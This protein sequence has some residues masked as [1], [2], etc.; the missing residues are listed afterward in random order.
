MDKKS[1]EL[2][3]KHFLN[4]ELLKDMLVE[5][6]DQTKFSLIKEEIKNA[7]LE[8]LLGNTI[9]PEMIKYNKGTIIKVSP[10]PIFSNSYYVIFPNGVMGNLRDNNFKI[11]RRI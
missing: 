2:V 6:E 5:K 4:A 9:E 3:N 10:E 7:T 1:L 11:I 8:E